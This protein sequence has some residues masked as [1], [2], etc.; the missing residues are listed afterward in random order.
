[1]ERYDDDDISVSARDWLAREW[2]MFESVETGGV[3]AGIAVWEAPCP[4]VVLGR[5]N[6]SGDWVD[7]D[8]CRRDGIEI[9]HRCSGGGAVVVGPGCLNF[10]LCL[11]LAAR[12]SLA[13]V[14][15]S[16][17]FVHAHLIEAL[18]V[19]GLT[20]AATADLAWHGRKV[21]GNAQRRGRRALLHHGTLLYGFDP[22]MAER[23][24][25]DPP[26]GPAYRGG[27]RHRAFIGNLPLSGAE[28]RRRVTPALEELARSPRG[29]AGRVHNDARVS[30]R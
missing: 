21:S 15:A 5:S 18:D 17:H 30:I 6:R 20:I 7:A 19:P 12:P 24:L 28:L 13:D 29:C 25:R 8:A 22:E 2:R 11:S 27:R 1:M 23:Y 14:A 26:R 3:D 4:A 10:A 16:F 9:L